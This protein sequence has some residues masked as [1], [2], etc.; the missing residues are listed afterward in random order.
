M[1]NLSGQVGVYRRSHINQSPLFLSINPVIAIGDT[2]GKWTVLENDWYK[3]SK[4]YTDR[5]CLVQCECGVKR[6]VT[7]RALRGEI[8][9]SCLACRPKP[10]RNPETNWNFL[11]NLYRQRARVTKRDFHL[12]LPQLKV[13][14]LSHCVYCGK[15][16]S[17]LFRRK[18]QI[19]GKNSY[20]P[21]MEFRYSGIDRI[22]S[23]KG[24]VLGNVLS[25]C[26]E[27]NRIKRALPLD[28]FLALI[29]RI[30]KHNPSVDR[31][32]EMAAT[33]LDDPS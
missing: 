16:P 17:N 19:D 11:L 31:V 7:Y 4:K 5:A 12:T 23:A 26:W 6:I 32:Q 14:S 27:C 33:L 18:Y 30:Q 10:K 21:E 25:C 2:F 1:K 3:N 20:D 29:A 22:D 8:S 13:L 9:S 24:Y 15:E 28:V